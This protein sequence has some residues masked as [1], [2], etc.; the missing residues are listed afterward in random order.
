MSDNALYAMGW[1]GFF[2]C[3]IVLMNLG[4]KDCAATRQINAAQVRRDSAAQM[5]HDTEIQE[6]CIAAGGIL[7][8]TDCYVI[9][10]AFSSKRP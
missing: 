6:K 5:V 8:G 2:V 4:F 3:C 7:H 10:G 9:S 1:F